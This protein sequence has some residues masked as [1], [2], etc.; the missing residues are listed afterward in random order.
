[1]ATK[2]WSRQWATG[3]MGFKRN[4]GQQAGGL[5]S[6]MAPPP[7]SGPQWPPSV[8]WR[9]WTCSQMSCQDQQPML[10][11]FL[12]GLSAQAIYKKLSLLTRRKGSSPIA[13]LVLAKMLIE[14]WIAFKDY[15]AYYQRSRGWYLFERTELAWHRAAVL[16]THPYRWMDTV[17]KLGFQPSGFTH[18]GCMT[19]GKSLNLSES[20]FPH[21]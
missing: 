8:K 7:S 19:L 16:V 20:H 12:P 4:C 18:V 14:D 13:W 11:P 5:V 6:N 1:M 17:R 15:F 21:L 3:C 10:S 9:H 2:V